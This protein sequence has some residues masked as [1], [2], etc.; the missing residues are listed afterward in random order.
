MKLSRKEIPLFL[1][2]YRKICHDILKKTMQ[3]ID[4]KVQNLK[5]SHL[6]KYEPFLIK[7]DFSSRIEKRMKEIRKRYAAP[8]GKYFVLIHDTFLLL[9]LKQSE[10]LACIEKA[11]KQAALL[12]KTFQQPFQAD[13]WN[14]ISQRWKQKA[15]VHRDKILYQL[16]IHKVSKGIPLSTDDRKFLSIKDGKNPDYDDLDPAGYVFLKLRDPNMLFYCK[17]KKLNLDLYFGNGL[18]TLQNWNYR[19]VKTPGRGDIVVYISRNGHFRHFGI[20]IGKGLVQSKLGRFSYSG[21]YQHHIFSVP[22][23]Y[24]SKILFLKKSS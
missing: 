22:L 1:L 15:D 17:D 2:A 12:L 18:K 4:R 5:D 10:Q 16:S 19:C 20:Y 8:R 24:R 23:N 13:D 6:L 9:N 11:A 21:I 14:A 3:D 7:P